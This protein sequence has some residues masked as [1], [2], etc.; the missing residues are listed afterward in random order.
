[1]QI[2]ACLSAPLLTTLRVAVTGDQAVI[3]TPSAVGLADIFQRRSADVVVVEP[4]EVLRR[5]FPSLLELIGMHPDT[6]VVVYTL[7]SPQAMRGTVELARAGI[8]NVVLKGLDDT[9]HRFAALLEDLAG[10]RW[11]SPLFVCQ[12]RP[13]L[14]YAPEPLTIALE[15]LFRFPRDFQDVDDLARAAGMHRRT[16]ERGLRRVGIASAKLLV[17]SARVER[18]HHLMRRR[19]MTVREAARRLDY[20][21]VRL[22]A[23]QVRW[24]TGRSPVDIR[25]VATDDLVSVL[26]TRLSARYEPSG[27]HQEHRVEADEI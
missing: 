26:S 3:V 9:P 6:P 4:T 16:V 14:Q 27:Q 20:P 15:R 23:R 22:F 2:A 10:G 18:A 12:V 21:S 5:E 1:M 11:E 17:V 13:H 7:L 25:Q 19:R 24:A 8:R